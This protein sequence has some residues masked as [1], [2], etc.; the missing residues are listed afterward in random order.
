MNI[1]KLNNSLILG[2]SMLIFLC[3]FATLADYIAPYNP[4]EQN[5]L[6]RLQPPSFK[7]LFGTDELGRDVFSR[8]VYATRVSL[9]VGLISVGIATVIGTILGLIS[10]YYGGWVD[11]LIMRIVD[12][13]L[14]FPTFFLILLVIAFLKPSIYNIMVVIGLT[15]WPSL[16]RYVR[17]E[18]LKIKTA[19]YILSAKLAGFS[20]G[21]ILFVHILPNVLVPVVV[22]F[23]LGVGSAIL[24]ESGLSF[25]GLGVQP[26]EPSWGNILTAGKDYIHIAWWL[27]LFPGAAIFFTV[28]AFNLLGE[29]LRI[30]FSPKENK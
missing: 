29:G 11:T 12:I 10:G 7:H 1:K 16:T 6:Q 26:P 21:K 27:S 18:V 3:I 19:E 17:A 4:Y 8:M 24:T 20:S 28:V 30:H 9:L 14:C 25:L 2:C 22:T 23:S 5:L 13:I 15:S